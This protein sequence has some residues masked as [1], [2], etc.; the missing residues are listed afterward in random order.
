MSAA[1]SHEATEVLTRQCAIL[2][3]NFI[4]RELVPH[5]DNGEGA[6]HGGPVAD[7]LLFT[8]MQF[9]AAHNR[10]LTDQ[11]IIDMF[12]K[13]VVDW[14]P[15]MREVLALAAHKGVKQ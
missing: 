12:N 9:V 13:S 3:W 8:L 10:S 5:V 1:L 7:G 14:L 15:K 2:T 6:I 4:N 11:Q